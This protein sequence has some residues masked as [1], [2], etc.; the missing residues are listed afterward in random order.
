[1]DGL[2]VVDIPHE[3]AGEL[4]GLL[5]ARGLC[6]IP[7]IAPTTPG[8]RA[9]TILKGAR[10]FV[11][12]VMVKGV[13]GARVALA[14]D[15]AEHLATLRQCTTLP[16]AAG[17]GIGSG[18]QARECARYADGVVVGSALVAAAHDNRLAPLVRELRQALG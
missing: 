7:L 1:V 17:F 5:E 18:E 4:R 9:R 8:E 6:L 3:E 2:L 13:T 10:G 15:A 11:Y 16:I 12:Y 14:T